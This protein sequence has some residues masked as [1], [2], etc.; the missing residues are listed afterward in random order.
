MPP[1]LAGKQGPI[2]E[3]KLNGISFSYKSMAGGN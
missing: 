3:E 2:F 1:C